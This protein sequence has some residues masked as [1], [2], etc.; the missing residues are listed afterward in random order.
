MGLPSY[1][2]TVV[3]GQ[4]NDSAREI[5]RLEVTLND[6]PGCND[7]FCLFQFFTKKFSVPSVSTAEGATALTRI[8]SPPSSLAM[9]RVIPITAAF[10]AT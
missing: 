7:R 6:L 4:I 10:E 5:D 8:L 1:K 3:G 9:P 2:S